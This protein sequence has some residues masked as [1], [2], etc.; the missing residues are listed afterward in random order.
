[1]VLSLPLHTIENNIVSVTLCFI[2]DYNYY[3][4]INKTVSNK[5]RKLCVW[6]VKALKE[7]VNNPQSVTRRAFHFSHNDNRTI[8]EFCLYNE[9]LL[10]NENLNLRVIL[11]IY[12]NSSRYY[13]EV[14]ADIKI[15]THIMTKSIRSSLRSKYKITNRN[16]NI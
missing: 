13:S 1:M 5:N 8:F 6:I 2:F 10:I 3:Y 9:Y 16:P 11:G 4:K 12:N 7:C 15:K 14:M